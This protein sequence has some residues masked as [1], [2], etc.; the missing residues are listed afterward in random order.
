MQDIYQKLNKDYSIDELV[1]SLVNV[2]GEEIAIFLTELDINIPRSIRFNA[3]QKALNPILE[4]EYND[5]LKEENDVEGPERLE[6]S[7][8]QT[9]LTWIDSFSETQFENELFK[10]NNKDYDKAYLLEFW[11]N[12]VN[13]L[14]KEGVPK[15]RIATF[16]EKLMLK[17]KYNQSL[18]PVRLFQ[19]DIEP[20]IYDEDGTFDG[21]NRDVFAKRVVLSATVSELK[22]IGAKYN[23]K[24]PTRLTKIQVLEIVINELKHREEYIPEVHSELNDF[25]LKE[26]EDF[27]RLNNIIAFAYINKDQMIE[28]MYKDFDEKQQ[29]IKLFQKDQEVV[30]H[31]DEETDEIVQKIEEKIE[32]KPVVQKPIVEVKPV[33]EKAEEIDDV[34]SDI[35]EETTETISE[36]TEIKGNR[37][38]V[39]QYDSDKIDELKKEIISLKEIVLAL[40]TEVHVLQNETNKNNAKLDNVSKGLIPRWFKRLVVALMIIF[41]FFM[42]FIPLSYY[43]PDAPVISQLNWL[44]SQ[45]PFFGGRNF[46]EFIHKFFERLFGILV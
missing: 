27:A 30:A 37:P 24:V 25:N 41:I 4:Q 26:L 9:R 2:P 12:L 3:L 39:V 21:L 8:R 7:R 14:L 15:Q 19:K 44:F 10:F 5:L 31:L 18:P 36:D 11:K 40:Q 1:E 20:Y 45:V 23:I 13:F 22:L 42:I 34:T 28:Y 43:Y 16:I 17:Y 29:T 46:L 33:E 32:V 6:D 38:T 35:T